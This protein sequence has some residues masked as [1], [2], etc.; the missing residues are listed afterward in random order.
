MG[1]RAAMAK[2]F[3]QGVRYELDEEQPEMLADTLGEK[4]TPEFRNAFELRG[5]IGREGGSGRAPVRAR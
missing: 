2:M 3:K 5:S 4:L 1:V